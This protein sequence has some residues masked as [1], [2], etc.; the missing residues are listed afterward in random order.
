MDFFVQLRGRGLIGFAGVFRD[1][2]GQP[3]DGSFHYLF[4]GFMQPRI[5]LRT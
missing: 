5:R 4:D 1:G 3:F 2:R